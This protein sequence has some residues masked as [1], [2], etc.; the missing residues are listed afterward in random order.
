MNTSLQSQLISLYGE[1]QLNVQQEKER[2]WENCRFD[3]EKRVIEAKASLVDDA[4]KAA[5]EG[6]TQLEL[7]KWRLSSFIDMSRVGRIDRS[8]RSTIGDGTW[9][10]VHRY[11]DKS[12]LRNDVLIELWEY[13]EGL[14][15]KPIFIEG[16]YGS[17][18]FGVELI[19]K[20]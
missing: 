20:S 16:E 7:V 11:C 19:E 13:I 18:I 17:P 15:L 9:R 2:K 1:H 6:R 14:G 10:S 8:R 12:V 3:F 4:K 5:R